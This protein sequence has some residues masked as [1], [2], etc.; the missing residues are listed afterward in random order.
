MPDCPRCQYSGKKG[1]IR[2]RFG[3]PGQDTHTPTKDIVWAGPARYIECPVCLGLG[4]FERNPNRTKPRVEEGFFAIHA[5]GL[6]LADV[7]DLL[8]EGEPDE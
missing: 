3:V 7:I 2:V 8:P 4:S 1:H 5:E 6:E